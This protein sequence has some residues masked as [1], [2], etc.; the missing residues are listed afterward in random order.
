MRD[1]DVAV[2]AGAGGVDGTA[3]V[4]VAGAL[5]WADGDG[6]GAGWDL[7]DWEGAG[8]TLAGAPAPLL[9]VPQPAAETATA[10]VN[11]TDALAREKFVVIAH[12]LS[13]RVTRNHGRGSTAYVPI[14]RGPTSPIPG[15]KALVVRRRPRSPA[16]DSAAG[17]EAR[18]APCFSQSV[19]H[20][21]C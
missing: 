21:D 15:P 9:Y 3:V 8:V 19:A 11:T 7:A 14:G 4:E 13:T 16:A 10:H 12:P 5:T 2:T 1:R 18:D 20:A 17:E 6:D